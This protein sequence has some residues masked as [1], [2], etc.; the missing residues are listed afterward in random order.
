MADTLTTLMNLRDLRERLAAQTR[1]AQERAAVAAHRAQ[2]EA[3]AAA[4][5]AARA[6]VAGQQRGYDE[7]VA[8]GVARIDEI[9]ALKQQVVVH[10][11]AVADRHAAADRAGAAARDAD[12]A[13]AEARAEHVRRFFRRDATRTLFDRAFAA[14]L[15]RA[16]RLAEAES[17]AVALQRHLRPPG[18]SSRRGQKR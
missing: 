11:E 14:D 1:A 8:G 12:R 4:E 2:A 17:E 16:D 15:R 10:G 5:A 3:I 6:A 13:A 18:T 9:M 7:L